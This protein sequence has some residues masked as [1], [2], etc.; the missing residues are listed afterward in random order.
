MLRIDYQIIRYGITGVLLN[1]FTYSL[2]LCVTW[3][4]LTPR[5]AI[6]VLYPIG[7]LLSYL[8]H[9]NF[10][11]K[12]RKNASKTAPRYLGIYILG[13]FLNIT[14]I[15]VLVDIVGFPHQL[16]QIIAIFTLAA[17]SY[18][19]MKQFVFRKKKF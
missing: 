2:Y 6:T 19:S 14:L 12:D 17:F 16:A 11:F 1:I 4:W 13:Y 5:Q 18:F 9:K 10:T 15:Y 7:I 8:S 3:L